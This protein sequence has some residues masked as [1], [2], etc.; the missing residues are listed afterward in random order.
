M[1]RKCRRR[2]WRVLWDMLFI[3]RFW[4]LE[5]GVVVVGLVPLFFG[6]EKSSGHRDG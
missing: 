3:R 6:K 5:H 4:G 1:K 2:N